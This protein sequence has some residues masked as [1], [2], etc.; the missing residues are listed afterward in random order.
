MKQ[1]LTLLTLFISIIS[2][3][4]FFEDFENGVPGAMKQTYNIGQTTWVNFG[5]SACYVEKPTS[6]QNSAVF[7]N[8]LATETVKTSL[9]TP[10]LDLSSA[11]F[12]LDFK[13]FQREKNVEYSNE[14]SIYLS[15]DGGETWQL[16]TKLNEKNESTKQIQ[17]NLAQFKPTRYSVI[18]FESTQSKA[19]V[20]FPIVL[21]DIE[22]HNYNQKSNLDN[23][24]FNENANIFLN[25]NPSNGL[26]KISAKND[27]NIFIYDTNGRLVYQKEQIEQQFLFDVSFLNKGIYLVKVVEKNI[28]KTEKLILK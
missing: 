24:A 15:K 12:F 28:E 19:G 21:D 14:L 7:F 10:I 20:G 22:I 9:E 27:F 8:G 17:I 13:Y 3:A 23:T 18:R 4:Q 25:P 6:G 26:F 5:M 2:N 16:L 1:K 11:N